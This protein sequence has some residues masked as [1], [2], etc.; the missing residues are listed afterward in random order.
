MMETAIPGVVIFEPQVFGDARGYFR[1]LFAQFD[2]AAGHRCGSC[3]T[4]NRNRTTAYSGDCI[5]EGD[6]A[7]AKLY[8]SYKAVY[9][10]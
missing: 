1:T 9:S 3:R 10:T 8:A 5:S 2:E 7:Q 6:F 4:T